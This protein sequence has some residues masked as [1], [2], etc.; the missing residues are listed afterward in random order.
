MKKR[1]K[2]RREK[3]RKRKSKKRR[4]SRKSKGVKSGERSISISPFEVPQQLKTTLRSGSLQGGNASAELKRPAAASVPGLA[5][6]GFT[7]HQVDKAEPV[8]VFEADKVHQF[9][10]TDSA[11][12]TRLE[13]MMGDSKLISQL[14]EA[15]KGLSEEHPQPLSDQQIVMKQSTLTTTP[16]NI[17]GKSLASDSG[18]GGGGG[19][20]AAQP[21]SL[22]SPL[23]TATTVSP[24]SAAPSPVSSMEKSHTS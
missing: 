14:I 24:K 10:G 7:L 23:G 13:S 3:R 4:H 15:R 19:K 21:S 11:M 18:G 9:C 8:I 16:V 5:Q 2:K 6:T 1:D 17:R 22:I 20:V 12:A